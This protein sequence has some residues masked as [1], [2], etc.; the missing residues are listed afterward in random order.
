M[1]KKQ[2]VIKA[3]LKNHPNCINEENGVYVNKSENDYTTLKNAKK[4]NS[5]EAA[6]RAITEVW[7]V[8]EEI[9]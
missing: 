1:K 5:P 9:K 8:V 4:Y 2:W 3:D 7:E 6:Q